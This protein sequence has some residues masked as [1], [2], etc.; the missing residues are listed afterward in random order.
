LTLAASRA[1]TP[2]KKQTPPHNPNTM[3]NLATP[4]CAVQ[5][6]NESLQLLPEHAVWWP[7]RR[8]LF[9]ADL[10]LGKA[11]SY[12]AQ[13]NLQRLTLL[14]ER[15]APRHTVF[16][17]DF[18]HA[19]T[20]RTPALL[21]A[22][23]AWREQHRGVAMTL[24]RGNHD[25]H[26]GDPPL[27]LGIEVV[28]EPWLVGPFAACHHPQLHPTHLVLAGHTHP[29]VNLQGTARDRLRLPCFV[30]EEGVAT[31]PAFGAF[32]GGHLVEPASGRSLYAVGGG[33]VWAM[34]MPAR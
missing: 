21:Q 28:D 9:I 32:T 33:R 10:H 23:R 7:T 14:I 29:V 3:Q 2:E 31:L 5:W 25:S 27:E 1:K 11:A 17:G 12:R 16:L 4:H 18:L 34:P 26:A 13:D 8:T 22:L 19:A 30:K 24:V 20:G 15:H 6:A